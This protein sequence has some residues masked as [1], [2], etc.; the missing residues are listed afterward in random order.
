VDDTLKGCIP[1]QDVA[2]IMDEAVKRPDIF[3]G[4]SC[5]TP[6]LT[7]TDGPPMI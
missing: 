3:A 5:D 4:R 2:A 7:R 1:R 6:S